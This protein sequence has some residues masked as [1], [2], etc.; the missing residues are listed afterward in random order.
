[1]PSTK[2]RAKGEGEIP[3]GWATA[4]SGSTCGLPGDGVVSE[5]PSTEAGPAPP[6]PDPDTAARSSPQ[7][8]TGEAAGL[9]S[10]HPLSGT[11]SLPVSARCGEQRVWT[12]LGGDESTEHPKRGGAGST[13]CSPRRQ[14]GRLQGCGHPITPSSSLDHLPYLS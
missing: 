6:R 11:V 1:M 13:S 12:G 9:P 2:M 7:R 4:G 5:T 14:R 8:C 10:T 3:P